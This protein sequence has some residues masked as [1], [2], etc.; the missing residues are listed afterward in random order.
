LVNLL[1][2]FKINNMTTFLYAVIDDDVQAHNVIGK[3]M[4]IHDNYKCIGNYYD[5]VKASQG[6]KEKKP[7]LIFLDIDMPE[8]NGFTLLKNLSKD[9]KVIVTTAHRNYG[10]SGFDHG[11]LDFICKPIFPDRL[12]DALNRFENS[13]ENEKNLANE[14]GNQKE[15]KKGVPYIFASRH[16][17]KKT[18]RIDTPEIFYITKTGNFIMIYTDTDGPFYK[19][20]TLKEIF[21]TLPSD[22]FCFVNHSCIFCIDKIVCADGNNILTNEEKKEYVKIS[23]DMKKELGK[24]KGNYITATFKKP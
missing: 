16:K 2:K 11:V 6:L 1:S 17:E 10:A 8:L 20:D 19:I 24:I 12:F 9:I 4:H 15:K 22:E 5:V 14:L 13:F 21:E 7:D 18:I 3:L 23:N